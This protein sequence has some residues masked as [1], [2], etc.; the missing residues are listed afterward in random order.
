[1]GVRSDTE[2][3]AH[4]HSVATVSIVPETPIR[5]VRVSDDIWDAANDAAKANGETLSVVIRRALIQYTKD[6]A[7]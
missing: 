5:R 3:C 4:V 1:M 2:T 7:G 6:N